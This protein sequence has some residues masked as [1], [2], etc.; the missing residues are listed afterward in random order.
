MLSGEGLGWPLVDRLL[1]EYEMRLQKHRRGLEGVA[2]RLGVPAP[3]FDRKASC[4]ASKTLSVDS[5]R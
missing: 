2:E 4:V 3:T 5:Q 1:N